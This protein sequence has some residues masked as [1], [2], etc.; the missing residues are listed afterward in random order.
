MSHDPYT[1]LPNP[2]SLEDYTVIITGAGG[3]I[4]GATAHVLAAA[5]ADVVV[6]DLNLEAAEGVAGAVQ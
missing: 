4:G 6:S 2:F 3:A 5:G 1:R